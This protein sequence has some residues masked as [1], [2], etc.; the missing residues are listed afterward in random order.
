MKQASIHT[1]RAQE[2][3]KKDAT[4][5]AERPKG[6]AYQA[7]GRRHAARRGGS[8][9]APGLPGDPRGSKA[10][11]SHAL[12]PVSVGWVMKPMTDVGLVRGVCARPPTLRLSGKGE[13]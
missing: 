9:T 4:Q 5:N 10:A 12:T 3:T 2:A 13:K 11:A 8:E 6:R 7:I 1:A